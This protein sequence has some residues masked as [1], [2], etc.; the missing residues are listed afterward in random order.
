MNQLNKGISIKIMLADDDKDDCYFFEK[1]LK[2]IN[3]DSELTIVNDGE[4]LMNYLTDNPERLPDII[5]LDLSMP[6]K[7]G[8]E[9]LYEMKEINLLKVIPVILLSTSYPKDMKY[10]NQMI[11]ILH[12]LGATNFI[13][14]RGDYGLIKKQIQDELEIIIKYKLKIEKV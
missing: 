3:I 6:R 13:R 12:N 5:F 9:C 1:A 2:E 4:E 8:F 11:E 10:E 7:T 14:K